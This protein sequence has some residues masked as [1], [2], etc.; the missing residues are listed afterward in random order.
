MHVGGLERG[1]GESLGMQE[2]GEAG[3]HVNEFV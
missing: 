3:A 2:A 1:L